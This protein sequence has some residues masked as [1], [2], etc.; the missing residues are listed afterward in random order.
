MAQNYGSIKSMKTA[1]I[2]TIMIWSGDGNEGDLLSNIPKGWIL[3][4]GLTVPASRYPLLTS[5]IGNSY[6]GAT[7]G[8][9][10]PNY[11]GTVKIPNLTGR[12]MMDL[13]PAMLNLEAYQYGQP[14]ASDIL[15]GLIVD[16]GLT[17]SIPTLI[18]ADTDLAFLP[19][20]SDTTFIGKMT[21]ITVNPAT[22]Q[23]TV[24]TVPRKLGINHTPPH[25]H[26]GAYGRATPGGSPPAVYEPPRMTVGGTRSLPEGCG[27]L[28]WN[29]ASISSPDRA[30][31][32]CFGT[33]QITFYDE[34]TIIQTDKFNEFISTPQQD[35]S[36]IPANTA[37]TPVVLDSTAFT[38]QIITVPVKSHRMAAWEG[39]FPRPMET[40]N[41]R[42]YFG[43]NTSVVGA[44]G[45]SDDPEAVPAKVVTSVLI[46]AGQSQVVLPVST[47]I[48]QDYD[49]II[50]NM[51]VTSDSKTGTF[52]PTGT[53]VLAI[54]REGDIPSQYTYILELSEVVGGA[55]SLTTTLRFRHGTFPTTLNGPA[56]AQDPN[57]PSFQSHNHASFDVTMGAG[58]V[59]GPTTHPVNNMSVGNVSP[60]TITGALNIIANIANPSLN[61]VY[62]IRAY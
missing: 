19:L 20:D 44:T 28:S 43:V 17:V 59:S 37:N 23:T 45:L 42:N 6:G 52:I 9:T 1:K 61:V 14:N 25:R 30:P 60:D 16:D 54:V 57:S 27:T 32:W 8:G 39:M 7:V 31:Q 41:R 13:E 49:E 4:D 33:N 58:N 38:N 50:P 51:F 15:E 21:D 34:N 24:F 55:G 26:P 10:F 12:A 56:T 11:T 48:G 35:Y 2:G 3:C 53:R 36:G 40:S 46:T 29:E 18:S 62:L 22:F 47:T 5:V